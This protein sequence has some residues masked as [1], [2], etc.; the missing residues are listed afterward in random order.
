MIADDDI[1]ALAASMP[2][3]LRDELQAMLDARPRIPA[4]RKHAAALVF[5]NRTGDLHLVPVLAFD[6]YPK[7][8]PCNG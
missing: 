8:Q 3:D 2:A 4:Q 1:R 6:F 7:E 5:N